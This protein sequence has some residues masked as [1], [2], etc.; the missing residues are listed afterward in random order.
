MAA[1]AGLTLILVAI[2]PDAALARSKDGLEL[3][4]QVVLPAQLP[5]L[6]CATLLMESGIVHRLSRILEGVT[7]RLLKA[8]GNAAFAALMGAMTGYPAGARITADLYPDGG[9]PDDIFRC[10]ILSSTSGPA[11]MI[12]AVGAGML[13]APAAGWLIALSHWGSVL[14]SSVLLPRA[15]NTASAE[16]VAEGPPPRSWGA[17]L[18]DA[19]RRGMETFWTVGGFIMLFSVITGLMEYYGVLQA[20]SRPVSW[21]MRLVGIDTSLATS[22]MM[23]LVEVTVGCKQAAQTAAPLMDKCLLMT[24]MISLGGISITMQQLAFLTPCGLPAG[25]FIGVKCLQGGLSLVLCRVLGLLPFF[26]APASAYGVLPG[27]LQSLSFSGVFFLGGL[28]TIALT[29]YAGQHRAKKQI[30]R[31]KVEKKS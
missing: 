27:F 20:L 28:T 9:L 2:S 6:L 24:L 26:T 7:R 11:Y 14:L 18:G 22:L 4:L 17:A 3:F 16:P 21:L 13:A 30:F 12:G 25:R 8:P 31:H 23:G 10:A 5:F 15:K 29:L 19:V 1:A